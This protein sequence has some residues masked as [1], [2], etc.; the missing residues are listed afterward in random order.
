MRPVI[1]LQDFLVL[2][3]S[4]NY[5]LSGDPVNWRAVLALT[6]AEASD[7]DD[8]L[9]EVLAYLSEAYGF[10]KRRLGPFAVIH[11]IRTAGV[12]CRASD[13]RATS[14][15]ATAMLHDKG[16]DVV[17]NRYDP[18]TW[19]RLEEQYRRLLDRMEPGWR[20]DER[21]DILARRST[22][23]YYR[24]LG[25][26]LDHA[27]DIPELVR[28]KLAD[29]L[30]NTLDLSIDLQSETAGIDCFEY[31]FDVMFTGATPARGRRFRHPVPGKMNGAKRL[32]QLF[33]NVVFLTILR[34]RGMDRLD[35]PT[36]RLFQELAMASLRQTQNTL[37]HLFVY[38]VTD[39]A[40]Q[41][42]IIEDTMQYC[43]RGEISR[44]TRPSGR[45]PLDGLFT[46]RFDLEDKSELD[47]RL[48]ELY[49]DKPLMVR[50]SVAYSAVF[51]S[52]LYDPDFNIRGIDEAGIH[53]DT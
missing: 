19:S 46:S 8:L 32:Y 9:T 10:T 4:I 53:P 47:R 18:G 14:D 5:Q 40:Q 27:P 16:E 33:K 6:V 28:V 42:A 31:I 51:S 1:D 13:R 2:S 36:M 29:R 35:R 50:V 48:E 24:Y 23:T 30:D 43:Q 25:R 39:H 26:V 3:A 12:L 41:R 52:F 15:L 11:P 45:S 7:E 20:M 44:I 38:H 17:A 49:A 34:Q 37:V 21:V 22:E